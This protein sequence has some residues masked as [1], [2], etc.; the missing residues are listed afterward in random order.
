MNRTEFAKQ[1]SLGELESAYLFLGEEKLFHEELQ[2]ALSKKILGIVDE[3]NYQ[4]L[5][6]VKLTVEE[7]VVNLETPAFFSPKRL[8]WLTN[9]EAASGELEKALVK[10]VNNLA[11]GIYLIV[12]T[13]KLG[14][15]KIHQELQKL[16]VVVDCGQIA[17]RE[18]PFWLKQRAEQLGLKLTSL[19]QRIL[20]ERLGK[21]LLRNRTELEKIRTFTGAKGTLNETELDLLLPGEPEPNI[22]SLIDSL[23]KRDSQ[24]ALPRLIELLNAGE[25]ELKILA[26]LSRQFRNIIAAKAAKA[27]AKT[28][29]DLSSWLGINPYV[30]EKSFTQGTQF[31]LE[32]LKQILQ[33]L[34]QVD[35]RI[36]TGQNEPRLELELAV[37][38]I[39]LLGKI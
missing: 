20:S 19:Q 7:L 30:A 9:F 34:L 37:I 13:E 32:E 28:P 10:S 2:R 8:I 1:L 3:F 15:K 36:K 39:C 29:K 38:E 27:T 11:A 5:N 6:A 18:V 12:S 17:P 33:R 4:K 23:A 31:R 22:F 24:Q 21:D 16:L 26:T 35:Y 14:S 25:N